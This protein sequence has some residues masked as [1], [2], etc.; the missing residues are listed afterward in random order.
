MAAR[1]RPS[2]CSGNS[3]GTAAGTG[4]RR[5]YVAAVP[6]GGRVT[7]VDIGAIALAIALGVGAW[8][9]HPGQD[10]R[11]ARDRPTTTTEESEDTGEPAPA[12][13]TTTTPGAPTDPTDPTATTAPADP[14]ATTA[15]AA[16]TP[17]GADTETPA[18]TAPASPG[19]TTQTT[20]LS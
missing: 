12:D 4:G 8:R 18:T 20:D 10:A 2:D 9:F 6:A 7:L 1:R 11:G 15:P 5:G 16:D 13:S 14:T 17:A 3:P 19:P